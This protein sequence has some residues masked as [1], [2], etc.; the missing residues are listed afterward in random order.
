MPGARRVYIS[1]SHDSDEHSAEVKQFA[2]RLRADG[3]EGVLDQDATVPAEGWPKWI[4]RQLTESEY[5]IVVCSP[6]YKAEVE[7][8][9]TPVRDRGRRWE[10]ALIYQQI[11]NAGGENLRFIPVLIGEVSSEAIPLPLQG[12]TFYRVDE[13]ADYEALRRRLAGEGGDESER[14]KD[15]GRNA[16][17]PIADEARSS[18]PLRVFLCHSSSDKPAVRAL[19][20]RLLRQKISPWLDEENILP[21]QDW[22]AE[23]KKAI[24]A[25]D[26]VLVCLSRQATTRQGYLSQEIQH[27]LDLAHKKAK[28][29]LF[30]IPVRLSSCDVPLGLQRWQWVNLYEPSG[31]ERLMKALQKRAQTVGSIIPLDAPASERPRTKRW[32]LASLSL[33]LVTAAGWLVT[34]PHPLQPGMRALPVS[35]DVWY[36]LS[37][38]DKNTVKLSNPFV[39]TVIYGNQDVDVNDIVLESVRLSDGTGSGVPAAMYHRV[40]GFDENND[41]RDDLKLDFRVDD[42][43]SSQNL[44]HS[45]QKL[46]ITGY[47]GSNRRPIYGEQQV[48]FIP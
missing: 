34:K 33:A 5:V 40:K 12:T 11:Y 17:T 9:I 37:R 22:D 18:A 19:Y 48:R 1:Y 24:D 39:A 35:F 30:L 26:V 4:E 2:G 47:L 41:G 28:E 25:T 44:G 43:R 14:R 20:K 21:G 31:F 36:D 10:G 29:A 16:S 6:A 32:Q 13:A 45:P 15:G 27:A 3:I 7:G 38:T 23:I 46:K 8:T 42:L